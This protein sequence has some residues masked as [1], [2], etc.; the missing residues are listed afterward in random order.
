MTKRDDRIARAILFLE[1]GIVGE[2][3]FAATWREQV[4][5][6]LEILREPDPEPPCPRRV[7]EAADRIDAT[8][9]GDNPYGAD[10]DD[11]ATLFTADAEILTR[12]V[13]SLG[14]QPAPELPAPE[15]PYYVQT[16]RASRVC[17][18]DSVDEGGVAHVVADCRDRENP[19]RG[20]AYAL[21]IRDAL[22]REN[23][24]SPAPEVLREALEDIESVL[25]NT[26]SFCEICHNH[27]PKDDDGTITG[28]VAHTDDCALNVLARHV[29]AERPAVDG[30]DTRAGLDKSAALIAL[31]REGI[32]HL[33]TVS[34]ADGSGHGDLA[35]V[36]EAKL[37]DLLGDG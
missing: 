29:L 13:T 15:G 17:L 33:A 30:S 36:I 25:G 27:A 8:Q 9:R 14:E 34:S 37:D 23:A 12:Y 19:A 21:Q 22:N 28:P 16:G 3:I 6:T 24:T 26:S 1:A 35:H 4:E 11:G 31:V 7:W 20:R 5:R 10:M 18:T 2:W 32:D